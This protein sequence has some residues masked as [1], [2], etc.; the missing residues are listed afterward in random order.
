MIRPVP[1]IAFLLFLV[2]VSP[3]I[4]IAQQGDSGVG[5]LYRLLPGD[6]L[7][8]SVWKEPELQREIIIRPDGF[9]SFP[10]VGDIEAKGKSVREVE[11][12]LIEKLDKYIPEPV[13]TVSVVEALGNRVFVIGQVQRP[14]QYIV[15]PMVD[16]LQ[17]LALAGGMTPF[18]AVNDIR[19]VRR[20]GDRLVVL[21]F[22]Y[23]EVEKGK[24]LNQNVILQAGDVV[25]V[26]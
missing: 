7:N 16:V 22:K 3:Q 21:D 24:N 11:R 2:S 9:F 17:A 6:N 19:V 18:A 14:G 15:N 20:S 23:G 13:L 12:E 10:L 1:S 8:V 25:V 5:T 26:P 4:A